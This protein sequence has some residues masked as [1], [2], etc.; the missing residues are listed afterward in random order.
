MPARNA[1]DRFRGSLDDIGREIVARNK[2]LE[3]PYLYLQPWNI[4]RS[5]AI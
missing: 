2:E 3:V 1:I 4:G 5:I